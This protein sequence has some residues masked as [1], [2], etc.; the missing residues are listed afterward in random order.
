MIKKQ[1]ITILVFLF[2]FST[3]SQNTFLEG[4]FIDNSNSKVNCLIKNEGW[5]NNPT[6]FKYKN[7][8]NSKV[9]KLTINKVK[10][11]GVLNVFKYQRHNVDIDRSSKKSDELD[12]NKNPVFNKEKLFL[13]LLIEGKANLYSYED[14]GLVRYFLKKNNA[15]VKQL[16]SKYYL[17][18]EN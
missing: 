11:F 16:V 3:F 1:L 14:R 2:V 15:D 8:I 5:L 7:K 18:D 4:Y 13:K 6:E 17:T 9:K 10:E 12:N